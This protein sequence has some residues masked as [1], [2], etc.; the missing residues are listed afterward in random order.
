[1]KGGGNGCTSDHDLGKVA[2]FM[3]LKAFAGRS[4]EHELAKDALMS[5]QAK[6]KNILVID[7]QT[8]HWI[9]NGLNY[10]I[11]H[12]RFSFKWDQ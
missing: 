2:V 8:T 1:M 9:K 6:N 3:A 4:S 5:F 7:K 10:Y 11:E 12:F